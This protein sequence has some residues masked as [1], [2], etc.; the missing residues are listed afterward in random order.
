MI[1]VFENDLPGNLQL[2]G[3]LSI[4]TET[5]GLNLRRDRLCLIQ[6]NNGGEDSYLIKFNDRNYDAPN[7]K[8]LLNNPATL[9]IFHYARF[10]IGVIW[11][12]LGIKITNIFCTK[13][14]SKIVRTYAEYHG[15]KDLC[16]EL[17]GAHISKQQQS[18][19][20][21]G[22]SLSKDQEEYAA[23][24]VIYLHKLKNVL[25]IMLKAEGRFDLAQKLFDFIP[26]RVELDIEGWS[27][28]D[29][30]AH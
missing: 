3:D 4:D 24:D 20:W 1:H 8:K 29:I 2:T 16:R 10:D 27:E 30:F 17:L 15:L 18:S 6:I 14:A 7:L 26:A 23:N 5:M 9:K 25:S 22:K 28:V 12:Y 21:G 11:Y 19:Y 13:I